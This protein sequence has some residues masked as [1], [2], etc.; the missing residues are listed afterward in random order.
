[1]ETHAIS[2]RPDTTS[3]AT[4]SLSTNQ[5][6]NAETNEQ[7]TPSNRS[8]ENGIELS[9]E[10]LKLSTVFQTRVSG[11]TIPS[12]EN[13]AEARKAAD[14]LKSAINNSPIQA[15]AAQSNLTAHVVKQML[16]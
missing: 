3:A 12:I 14:N 11:N 9:D 15:G 6:L 2:T 8:S 16:G 4:V 13:T 1:M 7:S 10:G 5:K